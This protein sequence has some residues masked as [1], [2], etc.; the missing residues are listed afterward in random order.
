MN[1]YHHKDTKAQRKSI[2]K[3][4]VYLS[5]SLCASMVKGV[6]NV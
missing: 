2:P 4:G 3:Y 6:N 5:L 1:N